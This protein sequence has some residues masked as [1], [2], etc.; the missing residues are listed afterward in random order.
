LNKYFRKGREEAR[1]ELTEGR[2]KI[3]DFACGEWE[4]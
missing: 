1:Y 3:E 4:N 2:Y